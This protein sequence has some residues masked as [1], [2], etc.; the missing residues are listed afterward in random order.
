MLTA[1]DSTPQQRY[2]AAIMAAI[3]ATEAQLDPALK[4][5]HQ[6]YR[7]LER[8]YRERPNVRRLQSRRRPRDVLRPIAR[9][10]GDLQHR[11]V[12]ERSGQVGVSS[13][14]N[15]GVVS[16]V[17]TLGGGEPAANLRRQRVECRW[18]SRDPRKY[19]VLLQRR[20][21]RRLGEGGMATVYLA[22]DLRHGRKVALKVL[23]PELAAIVGADRF[24]REIRTTAQL[25]HP[26]ILPL[27]DSGSATAGE[28]AGPELLY[29][30]MPFIEGESLRSRLARGLGVSETVIQKAGNDRMPWFTCRRAN[31]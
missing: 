10:A 14:G 19:R 23:R 15:G 12:R 6:G 18:R 25:Q 5:G 21:E 4:L 9:T 30:V 29:Y 3:F 16:R 22:E 11:T 31:T 7:A 20:I 13:T 17:P 1:P 26:H 27:Y 28:G 8:S 2:D 24:V